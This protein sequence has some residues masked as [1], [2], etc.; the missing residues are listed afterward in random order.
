[1]ATQAEGP[2]SLP[3]WCIP[4]IGRRPKR[5]LV[6]IVVLV[7]VCFVVFRFVLAPV[8]LE[9][10]SMLPTYHSGAVHVVNRLAYR[11]HEPRRGDVVAIK[12]A[13][14]HVMLLKRI[15]GMPGETV[16]F[17]GGRLMIDGQEMDEPYLRLSCDW[18]KPPETN[19]PD[20]YYVV[21]DNRSMPFRFHEQGQ[22]KRWRIFGKLWL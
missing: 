18:E 13:G 17:H 3:W 12:Y 14:E 22:S 4:L 6:R 15:V 9:G 19:G 20:E 16:S 8:R 7:A 21:G 1:M 10:P 5:T 2:S 11:F